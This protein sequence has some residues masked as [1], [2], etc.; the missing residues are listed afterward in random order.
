[1]LK[2]LAP[3]AEKSNF[4]MLGN[5]EYGFR[6]FTNSKRPVNSPD[7]IKGMKVRVPPEIQL[8]ACMA[9]LGGNV[10]KIAFP[11]L[12]LALSQGVVDAE[13]NPIA[14][15]YSNKFFEIQKHLAI[16]KHLYQPIF[17]VINAKSWAKL[18]PEQQAIMREESVAAGWTMRR[19]LQ[20]EEEGQIDKMKAAGMLVTRPDLAPFRAAMGPAYAKI[21]AYAGEENVKIFLKYADEA[22][23][24]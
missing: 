8:E 16:T 11:E 13:E 7:D 5:W 10:Q 6:Q 2:W 17:H 24:R 18:T 12:Y 21:G 9:A 22:R 14:T 15:I 19:Q 3:L 4:V 23:K 20:A 1:M